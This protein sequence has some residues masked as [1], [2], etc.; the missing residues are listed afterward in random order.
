MQ[1]YGGVE[2]V[3]LGPELAH[4]DVRDAP[5]AQVGAGVHIVRLD[6]K[7]QAIAAAQRLEMLGMLLDNQFL[8]G[9]TQVP[10]KS[11][12]DLCAVHHPAGHDREIPQQ[13]VPAPALELVA[14]PFAPVLG[15]HLPTVDVQHRPA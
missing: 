6:G 5:Q 14:K 10:Q 1:L 13:I 2:A 9:Q 12:G 11:L 8:G 7:P 15:P 4:R 3:T